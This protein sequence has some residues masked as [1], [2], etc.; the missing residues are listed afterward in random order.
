MRVAYADDKHFARIC[1]LFDS[2]RNVFFLQFFKTR[3]N[4]V[5]FALFSRADC[6][7]VFGGRHFYR[8]G[9]YFS[10]YRQRVAGRDRAEFCKRA[11]IARDYFVGRY[12]L[13]TAQIIYRTYLL[14]FARSAVDKRIAAF[15]RS[16]KN[17]EHI[18]SADERVNGGF[19]N[20]D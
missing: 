6:H 12:L 15:N 2:E 9:N 19:E 11:Y 4:L 17:F 20:S 13:F 14:R 5:F 8:R 7:S 1:V 3:E 10:A 18:K 16:V